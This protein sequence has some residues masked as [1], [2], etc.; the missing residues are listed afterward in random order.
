[1]ADTKKE[2]QESFAQLVRD[3]ET[4]KALCH[5]K[6]YPGVELK[7]LEH[8][9]VEPPSIEVRDDYIDIPLLQDVSDSGSESNTGDIVADDGQ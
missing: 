9:H 2:Q 4:K 6:D 7:K 3:L 5:V 8:Y 1:M